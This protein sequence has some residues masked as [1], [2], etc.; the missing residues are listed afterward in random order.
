MEAK[1]MTECSPE[2][3]ER[4]ALLVGIDHY[5][6]FTPESQLRG[7]GHDIDLMAQ[8]L[9]DRFDFPR[10]RIRKLR[11]GEAT[12]EGILQALE[13]LA[14]NVPPGAV[15]VFHFSG[16]GSQM[17]SD[18]PTEGDGLDETLVPHDSG[19]W[20]HP[21]RDICDKEIYDWVLRMSKRTPWLTLILDSC[22]S[23]GGVRAFGQR[24]VEA[25]LRPRRSLS[26]GV[27]PNLVSRLSGV[28]AARPSPSPS[29]WL[30]LAQRYVLLAGSRDG[31]SACE[32]PASEAG[33]VPHGAWSYF[34][35]RQLLAAPQEATY[36]E[37]FE[38]CAPRT[39]L[40]FPLQHPQL[41]GDRDRQIFG[42]H[43]LI[44]DPYVLVKE[45]KESHLVTLSGGAAHGLAAGARWSVFPLGTRRVTDQTPCLG[46]VQIQRVSA[47]EAVAEIIE[48]AKVGA[49]VASLR[50]VETIPATTDQ[51]LSVGIVETVSAE[52]VGN[53][54]KR[55]D[56]EICHRRWSLQHRQALLQRL[57]SSHR[58]DFVP[59]EDCPKVWLAKVLDTP[60]ADPVVLAVGRDGWPLAPPRNLDDHLSLDRLVSDLERHAR[61]RQVLDLENLD[62]SNPLE[63][64]IELDVL[65]CPLRGAWQTAEEDDR[66]STVLTEGDG[67]AFRIVH[68][69]SEPL[70][71]CILDLGLTGAIEVL[72]PTPGAHESLVSDRPLEVGL[73]RGEELEVFVPT[74]FPFA[75][76]PRVAGGT[77]YLKLLA[78]TSP[79]DFTLLTQPGLRA[80]SRGTQALGPLGARLAA[81]MGHHLQR[82]ARRAHPGGG[83]WTAITRRL[84]VRRDD[85]R[86]A[87]RGA[88]ET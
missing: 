80:C 69:H 52:L 63:T 77:A 37:V 75:G 35:C 10:R 85:R 62:P 76:D 60:S 19:R 58:L 36:L 44:S 74:E 84:Y 8:V 11:D 68:R 14:E 65:R 15:V 47:V 83:A 53:L 45:R 55:L 28:R 21:N 18:D 70:F 41:E 54:Q 33:G 25:D 43:S 72:Y 87:R 56:L 71:L 57:D 24:R 88:S 12:R 79:A 67:L 51:M 61:F 9:E 4:Y 2:S 17:L 39:N 32:L 50:A 7:C 5:P 59:A 23:G 82:D 34:L 13:D 31:E 1:P 26:T 16:H 27:P 40:R 42:H 73:R 81:A 22:H 49:I 30:P 3:P 64:C 29:G 20:E 46:Q 38:R 48:E 6:F 66:G 86:G 78:T